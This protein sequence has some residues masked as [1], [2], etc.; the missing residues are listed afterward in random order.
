MIVVG[1]IVAMDESEWIIPMVLQDKK[2]WY[3]HICSNLS[4]LNDAC[5][6]NPFPTPFIKEILGNVGG[7]EVYSFTNGFSGYH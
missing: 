7:R 6:H 3:I 4:N 5:V 1:I 2:T